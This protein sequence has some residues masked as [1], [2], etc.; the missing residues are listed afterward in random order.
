[1]PPKIAKARPPEYVIVGSGI[2]GL[3]AAEV[4]RKRDPRAS[5]SMISE[6]THNF[7]SRPGLAYLLRGDIPEKLLFIRNRDDL[8]AL[9]VKRINALVKEMVCD[10]QEL[11]VSNGQRVHYDRLLLAPGALAT[12]PPF[13]KEDLAGLVKLDS[14]DDTRHILKLARHGQTAVVVGGGITALELA[15]GLAARRMRVHYFLRGELYW[16]DV[17]DETESRIVMDRLRH[18]GVTIHT[19]T[20]VKQLHS[21]RG[22]LTAVET[23][24]GETIPCTM[25]AY[26]IGVRPRVDLAKSAG[27]KV[28]KGI[29]VNEYLETGKPGVYAAGDAA[30]VGSTPLDVLWPTALDQGRIAGANMAGARVA[31]VKGVACNVTML[32]GLKV[33]IIGNVGSK[34][35]EGGAKKDEDLVAIVRGDSES[36]RLAP[37]AWVLSDTEDIN[38]VRL[39]IGERQIVGALVMGD[40]TW[41]HPLQK[42]ITAKADITPIRPQLMSDAPTALTHLA[43]FYQQ[44][45]QAG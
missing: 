13:I 14:L 23:E 20:Q 21:A 28:D 18:E 16:S 3:A 45:E 33:T 42:L 40:Q 17:L 34:K 30:Q 31:Y 22:R 37:K 35:K 25:L 9:N 24:A 4:L 7:Y 15:E 39:F 27:L 41:S 6:E 43:N 19:N 29:V 8:S 10:K 26:A 38:R 2:A 36:W 11:V 5:I 32:T 44:W 12:R 1:M